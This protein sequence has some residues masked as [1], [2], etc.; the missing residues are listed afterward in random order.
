LAATQTSFDNASQRNQIASGLFQIVVFGIRT[1]IGDGHTYSFTM[2][3][4]DGGTE[5]YLVKSLT[6]SL[7]IEPIKG[8]LKQSDGQVREKSCGTT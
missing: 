6:N 1:L 8:T 7:N 2:T 3:F 4:A 5:D